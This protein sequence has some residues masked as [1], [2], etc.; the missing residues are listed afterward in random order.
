[1]SCELELLFGSLADR[2]PDHESSSMVFSAAVLPTLPDILQTDRLLIRTGSHSY[3]SYTHVCVDEL[4]VQADKRTYRLVALALLAKVFHAQPREVR[5]RLTNPH[6]HIH[7]LVLDYCHDEDWSLLPGYEK[8]AYQYTYEPGD[9]APPATLLDPRALPARLLPL[10][11]RTD[12]TRSAGPADTHATR[13]TV[14]GAGSDYG[15]ILFANVLLNLGR[16]AV[17]ISEFGLESEYGYGGVGPGS[18]EIRLW[19]PGGL[20]WIDGDQLD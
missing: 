11:T 4:H 18:A 19:L 12:A 13:D 1:M 16:S 10:F 9:V 2:L 8:R 14:Y 7:T 3:H 6:S 15:M 20:G 17:T 5:L